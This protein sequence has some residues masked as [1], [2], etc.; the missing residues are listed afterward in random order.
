MKNKWNDERRLHKHGSRETVE[1]RCWKILCTNTITH[2]RFGEGD[3]RVEH[4]GKSHWDEKCLPLLIWKARNFSNSS[5]SPR[6][7]LFFH[8]SPLACCLFFPSFSMCG[9]PYFFLSLLFS[10]TEP[11]ERE[12]NVIR[13]AKFCAARTTLTAREGDFHQLLWVREEI[14]TVGKS[15]NFDTLGFGR[16][17][18]DLRHKLS[19]FCLTQLITHINRPCSSLTC[20][21]LPLPF[22]LPIKVLRY[23][24]TLAF[25]SS[26]LS[27]KGWNIVLNL[28]IRIECNE[29]VTQWKYPVW[30]WMWNFRNFEFRLMM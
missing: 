23:A 15:H 29:G 26:S 21:P 24:S 7:I 28:N 4:E 6:R 9:F 11:T 25:I 19:L 1:N 8:V 17:R 18:D 20:P 27:L 30:I 12:E 14:D 16:E 2:K 22:W 13:Q 3:A 5:P 10:A